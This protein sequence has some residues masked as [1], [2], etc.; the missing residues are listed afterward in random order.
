MESRKGR[1]ESSRTFQYPRPKFSL[2]GIGH[3]PVL[4]IYK[5]A[6]SRC[7]NQ[8]QKFISTLNMYANNSWRTLVKFNLSPV[9]GFSSSTDNASQHSLRVQITE[10]KFG[11]KNYLRMDLRQWDDEKPLAGVSIGMEDVEFLQDHLESQE[12]A[13]RR[14][15]AGKSLSYLLEPQ[16]MVVQVKAGKVNVVLIDATTRT[17]LQE[18]LPIVYYLM[19]RKEDKE[20]EIADEILKNLTASKVIEEYKPTTKDILNIDLNIAITKVKDKVAAA[21]VLLADYFGLSHDEMT[22]LFDERFGQIQPRSVFYLLEYALKEDKYALIYGNYIIIRNLFS[23]LCVGTTR[24][25]KRRRERQTGPA[26][27]LAK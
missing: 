23:R 27:K 25:S 13:H 15:G 6:A 12:S 3:A 9:Q 14:E 18:L 11:K 19:E 2:G 21:F 26:E 10:A 5:R 24:T 1:L 17:H 20:E 4:D 7:E 16:P 8:F 22:A